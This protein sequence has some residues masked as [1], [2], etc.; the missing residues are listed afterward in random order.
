MGRLVETDTGCW[1]YTGAMDSGGYGS[2]GITTGQSDRT[3][4]VSWRLHYGEIPAGMF[5]CHTCDNRPCCRPDHLF[6][7]TV[8]DNNADRD[9]KG[10]NRPEVMLAVIAAERR[11]RTSCKRGHPYDEVNTYWNRDK[12]ICRICSERARRLRATASK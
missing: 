7:G 9:A 1:E 11:A 3:H 4:R 8:Q 2:I 12:R 6:L 10:R 5:V